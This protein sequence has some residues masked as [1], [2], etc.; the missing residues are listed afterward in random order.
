MKNKCTG[1]SF[2]IFSVV[3][4]G[5]VAKRLIFSYLL[6][7]SSLCLRKMNLFEKATIVGFYLDLIT[8]Y[9]QKAIIIILTFIVSHQFA[10]Q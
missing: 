9:S 4:L 7:H 10:D 5:D 2:C 3:G 6:K 1:K 8:L